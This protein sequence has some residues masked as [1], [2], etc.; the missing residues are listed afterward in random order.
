MKNHSKKGFIWGFH[1]LFQP[2]FNPD[3][4]VRW[5]FWQNWPLFQIWVFYLKNWRIPSQIYLEVFTAYFNPYLIDTFQDFLIAEHM[6]PCMHILEISISPLHH[7]VVRPTKTPKLA[8]K[9][10]QFLTFKVTFLRQKLSDSFQFFF[11]WGIPI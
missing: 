3:I 2:L 8:D 10:C 11:R 7:V 4:K 1:P 6:K 5:F 9:K